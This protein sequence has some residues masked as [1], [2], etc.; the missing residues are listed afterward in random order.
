[1][2]QK[3]QK[4]WI[5]NNYSRST[6]DEFTSISDYPI[7]IAYTFYYLRSQMEGISSHRA[8]NPIKSRSILAIYALISC[9]QMKIKSQAISVLFY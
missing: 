8:H 7:N 3:D 4:Y 6:Y 5:Y 2:I 1:M 9:I